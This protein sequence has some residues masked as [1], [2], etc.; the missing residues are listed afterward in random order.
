LIDEQEDDVY[1]MPDHYVKIHSSEYIS[2][3]YRPMLTIFYTM[4]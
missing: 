4:P 2:A 3:V 1:D